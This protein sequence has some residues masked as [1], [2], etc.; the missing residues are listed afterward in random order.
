MIMTNKRKLRNCSQCGVRH[1]PP[2]GKFCNRLEHAFEALNEEMG[3]IG[4]TCKEGTERSARTEDSKLLG[5]VVVPDQD[6]NCSKESESGSVCVDTDHDGTDFVNFGELEAGASGPT[7]RP[8]ADAGRREQVSAAKL[9]GA[10]PPF[11]FQA[12]AREYTDY[13][14]SSGLSGGRQRG[15]QP[16]PMVEREEVIE[17]LD[18]LENVVGKVCGVYQATME[19]FASLANAPQP[20][21]QV[22]QQQPTAPVEAP[23]APQVAQ[24]AS[25]LPEPA[26]AS[27]E[28]KFEWDIFDLT[29]TNG[30]EWTDFHGREMWKAAEERKRKNPFSR[31][32]YLKKGEKVES[33]E[34]LMVVTLKTIQQLADVKYDVSGVVKH[35]ITMAEKAAKDVFEV[36]AFLLYDES[37]R[38]RAGQLGPSAF[39]Q[40]VQEDSIRFF[41]ADNM[42]KTSHKSKSAVGGQSKKRSDKL[43]IRFNDGGCNSKNC[44]YT[45]K[46]VTC[47]D[48]SH[49]N[50]DCRSKKKDSK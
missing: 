8:E 30:D 2:F 27:Q 40:V 16:P 9:P 22:N 11:Q 48:T 32:A 7:W 20:Q 26:P 29:S 31:V 21:P 24:A 3:G 1:G 28:K 44:F 50:K 14:S 23:A 36:E 39:G 19:R 13:Q 47:N 45:H 46:C 5:G 18:R 10:S 33:F 25:S 41:S 35:G 43:C 4:A 12:Q 38:E 34:S 15:G 17:R 6:E 49:G 42:K 37:V